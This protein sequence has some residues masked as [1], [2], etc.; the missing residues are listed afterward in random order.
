M[1]TV[2]ATERDSIKRCG[3]IINKPQ[4]STTI[5]I[6]A[7][8]VGQLFADVLLGDPPALQTCCVLNLSSLRNRLQERKQYIE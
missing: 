4:W 7:K 1:H 3:S 5:L 6:L 8:S 2:D